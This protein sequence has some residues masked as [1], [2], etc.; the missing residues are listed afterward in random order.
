MFQEIIKHLKEVR[1]VSVQNTSWI[2]KTKEILIEVGIIVFAVSLSI[3]LHKKVE[4]H[5]HLEEA[6]EFLHDVH[7]DIQKDKKE[8]ILAKQELDSSNS[9][10]KKLLLKGKDKVD[11]LRGFPL[12]FIT[13]KTRIGNY[14]S[15]KSSGKIGYIPNKKIKQELLEYYQNTIPQ[16]EEAEQSY[17]KHV[18]KIIDASSLDMD[19]KSILSK[20]QIRQMLIYL[21]QYAEVN[22]EAYEESIHRCDSLSELIHR[23]NL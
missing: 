15:F 18:D 17:N 19:S 22:L 6:M 20:P 8:F 16:M 11:T 12:N 3:G 9:Y 23:R 13:R 4:Q 7:L 14:E 5:E 21:V 2:K 1:R 10:L